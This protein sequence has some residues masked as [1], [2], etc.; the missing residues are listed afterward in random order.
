MMNPND[1]QRPD[2]SLEELNADVSAWSEPMDTW[3]AVLGRG[4]D[5]ARR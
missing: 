5:E 3:F 1:Y 2:M 4:K